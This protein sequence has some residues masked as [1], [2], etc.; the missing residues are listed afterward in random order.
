MKK[1]L[2][3]LSSFSLITTTS[4]FV[5]SCKTN[6]GVQKSKENINIDEE[7][8]DPEHMPVDDPN[9]Y[10]TSSTEEYEDSTI[11][12]KE[13]EQPNR[14]ATEEEKKKLESIFK[15]QEN[16]FDSS[17][18]YKDVVDQ[19]LVYANKQGLNNITLVDGLDPNEYLKE[20]KEGKGVNVVKLKLYGSDVAFIPKKVLKK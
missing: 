14:K 17:H 6:Q 15:D 3:F 7:Y 19:L 10:I 1:L 11:I 20:D 9:A 8:A 13:N 16:S 2:T 4:L 5:I 12:K 18:T